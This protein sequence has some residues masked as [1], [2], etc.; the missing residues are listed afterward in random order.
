MSGDPSRLFLCEFAGHLPNLQVPS[1]SHTVWN[2][3]PLRGE[4]LFFS[5]FPSITTLSLASCRLLSVSF[6]R[7]L[8]SLP[9]LVALS[10]TNVEFTHTHSDQL[11][12]ERTTP[13]RK[14]VPALD[15]LRFDMVDVDH[16]HCD[17]LLQWLLRSRSSLR[18]LKFFTTSGSQDELL[19]ALREIHVDRLRAV[20][21]GVVK[22]VI[23]A[24]G[25]FPVSQCIQMLEFHIMTTFVIILT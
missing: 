23:L 19:P 10:L 25:M 24:Y 6:L 9:R 18:E 12:L 14:S 7:A 2:D 3:S 11:T 16:A 13:R 21:L 8:T 20:A 15:R 17:P 5:A 1:H 22:L 4:A